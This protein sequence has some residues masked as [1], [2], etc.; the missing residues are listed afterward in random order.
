MVRNM[1]LQT[2]VEGVNAAEQ[3]AVKTRKTRKA[4]KT[5][6]THLNLRQQLEDGGLDESGK[7]LFLKL[8][9]LDGRTEK[10]FREAVDLAQQFNNDQAS[11]IIFKKI[12]S[13]T[14]QS[15]A[16]L[17]HLATLQ[18]QLTARAQAEAEAR[19][20][21][22]SM[23][24]VGAGGPLRAAVNFAQ[25]V[26]AGDLAVQ[27]EPQGRDEPAQLLVALNHMTASLASGAVR[28]LSK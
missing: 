17:H 23:V 7:A 8:Q 10:Q 21:R 14:A 13:L 19:A 11:A 12:D 4:R 9:D 20:W 5:R 27:A 15:E 3:A 16:V 24:V 6:K 2:E 18:D 1:G 28:W 26:A 22:V 25:R